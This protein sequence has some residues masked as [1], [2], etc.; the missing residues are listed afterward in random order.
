MLS[1]KKNKE[2]TPIARVDGGNRDEDLLY[3]Y[4]ESKKAYYDKDTDI[5]DFVTEDMF[6]DK[7]ARRHLKSLDIGRII[8]ALKTG[9]DEILEEH[10]ED[11]FKNIK[12]IVDK[13]NGKEVILHSGVFQFL[14]NEKITDSSRH[15]IYIV[16]ESGSGKSYWTAEYAREYIRMFPKHEVFLFSK[17]EVDKAFDTNRKIQRIL[18]D[19]SFLEGDELSYKDFKNSLLIFDDIETMKDRVGVAV[20]RLRQDALELGRSFNISVCMTEHIACDGEKTKPLINES[21]HYVFFRGGN[22]HNL[23]RLLDKYIGFEDSKNQIKRIFNLP[24]KWIL[25]SKKYPKYV[26]HQNGCYIFK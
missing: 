16:G 9:Q 5:L 4:E 6:Y 19:E 10:L 24:S 11:T 1:F 23:T 26:L 20:K 14:P 3:L 12:G 7:K 25:V 17:K 2:G 18:L 21:T 13:K 8:R 15:V 22:V